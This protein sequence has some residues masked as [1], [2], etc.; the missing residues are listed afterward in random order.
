MNIHDYS[1]VTDRIEINE[2]C[3]DEVLNMK[4]NKKKI[5]HKMNKKAFIGIIAAAVVACG[6]TAVFA[7][8]YF[9]VFDRLSDKKDRTFVTEQGQ[10]LKA[11]KYDNNN[12]DIIGQNAQETS[13]SA[14]TEEFSMNVESVYCD[15]SNLILG[16]TGS[17]E[18]G[19]TLNTNYIAFSCEI[20]VD[21]KSYVIDLEDGSDDNYLRFS[22]NIIRDEGEENS[23]TGSV[24]LTLKDEKIENPTTADI[25][26]YDITCSDSYLLDSS[27]RLED[28][29][30]MSVDIVPELELVKECLLSM[31][32]DGFEAK[33]YE[34]SPAGITVGYQYPE[35]YDTNTETVSWEED[36][37]ILTG[38]KYSIYAVYCDENGNPLEGLDLT[39]CP[40]Y[41][42][43]LWTGMLASTDSSTITVKW[44][45]KQVQDENGNMELLHEYTFDISEYNQ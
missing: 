5:T 9:R 3:R 43:G 11:D 37:Q 40:D 17:F 20:T 34:I 16:L 28:E 24:S 32:E 21:G 18:D 22:G 36:G 15:G 35:F 6:G 14:A 30:E 31:S 41:G 4:R 1:K 2:K 33:I 25:R 27:V 38:P 29:I 45:N 8:D 12:Y 44:F 26:F 39:A 19:N 10:E 23:F 7:A 13:A 42:D